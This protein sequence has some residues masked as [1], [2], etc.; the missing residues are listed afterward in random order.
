MSIGSFFKNLYGSAKK[1]GGNVV[2]TFRGFGSKLG[3]GLQ[4]IGSKIGG[5][6]NLLGSGYNIAKNIPILG[7][8]IKNTPVGGII[9]SGLGAMGSGGNLLGE[10][11]KGNIE[12]AINEGRNL[13]GKVGAITSK[14]G[15]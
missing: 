5:F 3:G 11:G 14:I 1:F 2:N 4:N 7:D 15:I 13:V 9:E 10:L 8:V 12:G 6:A